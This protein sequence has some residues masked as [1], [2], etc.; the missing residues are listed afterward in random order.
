MPKRRLLAAILAFTLLTAPSWTSQTAAQTVPTTG[1]RLDQLAG[2]DFDRVFLLQMG[3]HELTGVLLAEPAS[4]QAPHL[5]VRGFARQLMTDRVAQFELLRGWSKDWYGTEL[6]DSGTILAGVGSIPTPREGQ[7]RALGD[8]NLA[9]LDDLWR[10]PPLR[11]EATFLSL[12]IAHN[13]SGIDMAV[14]SYD[15][16]AHQQLRDLAGAIETSQR[17]EIEQMEEWLTNWYGL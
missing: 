4:S 9:I 3:L 16:A 10:L 1:Q 5:E 2:D 8:Q 6:P 17:T 7:P 15:K 13:Q 11:L 14:S 12:M